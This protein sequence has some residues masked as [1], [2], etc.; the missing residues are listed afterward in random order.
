MPTTI[1]TIDQYLATVAT[2]RQYAMQQL[3]TICKANLPGTEEAISYGMIGYVVPF[4]VYPAGYH[5]KPE[6]QL[7]YVSIASQK[8][9]IAIYHMGIYC[10]PKLNDWFIAQWPK[11]TNSK[12]DMGKSCIR[13]KKVADIPFDLLAQLFAKMTMQQWI[14]A[15]TKLLKK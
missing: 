5:C 2:D 1:T 11:H 8:N 14:D 3:R 4:S 9:F 13:F 6:V 12:L 10:N 15:Y 7:P